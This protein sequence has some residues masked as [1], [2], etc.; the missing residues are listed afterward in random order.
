MKKKTIKITL[1][2]FSVLA[3]AILALGSYVKFALPNVGLAPELTIEATPE[4]IARGKYLANSVALCMDCHSQ[5]DFTKFSGP[6]KPETF[7]GGGERFG[8]ELGLP[9]EVYSANITPAAIGDWTDGEIYR[10]LTT[11][12]AK[13]GHALFPL[14]PYLA[15]AN[16]D[17]EDLYSIIAYIRTLPALENEVPERELDFPL[18]LI[19][20]TIPAKRQPVQK[21]DTNDLV[22]YGEYLVGIAG[23]TDCHT[24]TVKDENG[25]MAFLS[26][27]SE[28]R[29]PDGTII[30]S[31]NL[32]PHETGLKNWTQ[33]QFISR[34]KNSASLATEPKT[35][36]PGDFNSFMPWS[37]YATM[38]ERDLEAIYEYLRTIP[39]VE[40]RVEK[41]TPAPSAENKQLTSAVETK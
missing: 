31:A 15:Y 1:I 21:P 14:M 40:K 36:R 11:G 41:F 27:G 33:E 4:R 9:G 32:T 22:K 18:N 39:P 35:V 25:E 5:R 10:A 13:D 3:V 19:V 24:P 2:T 29:M 37:M 26:G 12:V 6:I 17:E 34:F 28:L 16:M 20:N 8:R 23:C 38:D 7:G 30:R